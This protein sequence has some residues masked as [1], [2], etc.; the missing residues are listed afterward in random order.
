M[1]SKPA[2]SGYAEL[3]RTLA[4][5]SRRHRQVGFAGLAGALLAAS[6]GMYVTGQDPLLVAGLAAA[7]AATLGWMAVQRARLGA[8]VI[9]RVVEHPEQVTS[10]EQIHRSRAVF[11]RLHLGAKQQVDLKVPA[12]QARAIAHQL[13]G[14]CRHA[15]L[16]VR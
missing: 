11:L 2:S 5:E 14:H 16:H 9:E 6:V 12:R 13:K 1:T 7:G 3:I 10:I 8:R 15:A 4:A